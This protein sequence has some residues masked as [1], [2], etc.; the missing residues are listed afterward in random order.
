MEYQNRI[1]NLK[2][3]QNV[4]TFNDGSISFNEEILVIDDDISYDQDAEALWSSI[5]NVL[6][7]PLGAVNGVG[8]ERFGS[9]LLELRGMNMN[10]HIAELAKVYINDTISQYQ[11][12]VYSFDEIKIS[13]P[14]FNGMK[15][16]DKMK[17]VLTVNSV[18]GRFTRTLYI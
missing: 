17:I 3:Q 9:R 5:C 12:R 16:G 13:N 2:S 6:R 8:M 15:R 11:N 14:T 4:E 1:Q 10:Y 7:T 18:Y